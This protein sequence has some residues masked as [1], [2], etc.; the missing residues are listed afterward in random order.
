VTVQLTE[1]QERLL[2]CARVAHLAT[3]D[4]A[5]NPHVVPICFAWLDGAAYTAIDEK[6]KRVDPKQDPD[7]LRRIRNILAHPRV[8]LLVDRYAEDWTRLA[9]LQVR[10]DAALVTDPAERASA[11]I[12]LR[13]RY[14]LYRGMN[15]ESMPLIRIAPARVVGWQATDPAAPSG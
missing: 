10:G 6:P 4:A 8:C 5:G 3:V 14:P 1:E 12:A 7:A 9:W 2:A 15:L 13:D 11:H